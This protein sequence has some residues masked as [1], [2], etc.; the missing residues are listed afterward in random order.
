[1]NLGGGLRIHL[2][3]LAVL[4]GYATPSAAQSSHYWGNQFGSESVLLNGTVIGSVTDIGAVYYN[5]ARILRRASPAF[6]VSAKIY[7][8]TSVRIENG[9]GAGN[10]LA[11]TTF[12]SAPGFLGGTFTLPFL[13]G[14]QFAYAML[15]RNRD[16]VEYS[17]REQ[18]SGDLYDFLPG[19]EDHFVGV[20]DIRTD[21]KEDWIGVAWAYPLSEAWS[22]G[23]TG[24]YFNRSAGRTLGLDLRGIAETLD[25]AALRVERAYNVGDQGLLAKVG[26]AW[27][28][29]SVSWGLTATTPYWRMIGNGSLLYEH[30]QTGVPGDEGPTSANVLEST[31]QD[32]LTPD[33]RTPWS[34]GIGVG[35]TTGDWLLQSS[36]EYFSAVSAHRVLEAD[37]VLGQSTGEPIEFTVSEERKSVFNGGLGVRWSPSESLSAFASAATNFSSAPDSVVR[38]TRLE[39]TV[40]HTS[41]RMDFLLLGGGV[42]VETRW[43]DLTLGATWQG[44]SESIRRILNLPE[45]GE[46]PE[47]EEAKLLIRHMRLMF[48]FSI[49]FSIPGTDEGEGG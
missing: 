38:F 10:D 7:D 8:W 42:S 49:P 15:S 30:F 13:E 46:E 20:V 1:M 26:V 5:P 34:V 40:S 35:W 33:W 14:H 3:A 12:G 37:P 22:V 9:L 21:F 11:R 2:V 4:I 16:Q 6:A 41:L 47:G 43:A 32:D 17:V 23:A 44:S 27:E 39:P 25:A 19:A 36:V 18:R 28:G 31:A 29:E 45:E 48:G 24:F